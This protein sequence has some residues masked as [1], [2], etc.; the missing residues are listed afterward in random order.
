M[1]LCHAILIPVLLTHYVLL[2][3][4]PPNRL[5]P[6]LALLPLLR[7]LSLTMPVKQVPQIYWY[8]LVGI[9][10]LIAVSLTLRLLNLS[11]KDLGLLPHRWRPQI[12]IGLSGIPL[13]FLAY[14]V[15]LPKGGNI[16]L[17]WQDVIIGSLIL[18]IFTGFTEEIIFRGLL[19]RVTNELY[20]RAGII[21]STAMF[22][23]M[24]I[25]SLSLAYVVFVG[26]LG[27][28]FGW[29]YNRTKSVWG[30]ALSHG[31][32]NVGIAF[33]WPF[34]F[35]GANRTLFLESTFWIEILLWLLVPTTLGYV[36]LIALRW[37]H[38][39]IV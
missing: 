11:W 35:A 24:Y 9:P 22:T 4:V 17:N 28:F 30:A 12:Y 39:L 14:I 3:E 23:T 36:V 15:L 33:I 26:L 18:I 7:I 27:L 2:E 13:S 25:G 38:R 5:L 10:I 31:I 8:A 37:L 6:V 1:I 21:Y 29:C 20:G 34:V 32:T 19:Q 16:V